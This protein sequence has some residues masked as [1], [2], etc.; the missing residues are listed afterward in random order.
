[1]TRGVAD[2]SSALIIFNCIVFSYGTLYVHQEKNERS[3]TLV[4][5]SA[6]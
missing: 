6:I 4:K 1:M 2:K 5:P 3:E